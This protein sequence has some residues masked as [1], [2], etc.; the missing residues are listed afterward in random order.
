MVAKFWKS[1]GFLVQCEDAKKCVNSALECLMHDV[2]VDTKK[3]VDKLLKRTDV[4]VNMDKSMQD[5]R[6]SLK[7][8]KD[9]VGQVL[10]HVQELGKREPLFT[11]LIFQVDPALMGHAQQ[12]EKMLSLAGKFVEKY[13]INAEILS[14][15]GVRVSNVSSGEIQGGLCRNPSSCMIWSSKGCGWVS[16]SCPIKNVLDVLK[17]QLTTLGL[18]VV[19]VCHTYGASKTAQQLLDA[20][21]PVVI[22]INRALMQLGGAVATKLLFNV[23]HPV[24]DEMVRANAGNVA[25]VQN[26]LRT[27]LGKHLPGVSQLESAVLGVPVHVKTPRQSGTVLNE[28]KLETRSNLTTSDEKARKKQKKLA[29]ELQLV[30]CDVPYPSKLESKMGQALGDGNGRGGL[31]HIKGKGDTPFFRGRAVAFEAIMSCLV[32]DTFAVVWRIDTLADTVSLEAALE[33][34]GAEGCSILIWVDVAEKA[35][36][37]LIGEWLGGRM[38]ED[39]DYQFVLLL[40]SGES[41]ELQDASLRLSKQL[42]FEEF[43]IS[44]VKDASTSLVKAH[45]LHEDLRFSFSEG[46]QR[47]SPFELVDEITFA[48]LVTKELPRIMGTQQDV[49]IAGF[50]EDGKDLIITVCVRDV[51][52]IKNL[53]HEV[54]TGFLD[55]KLGKSLSQKLSP[56]DGVNGGVA[57]SGGDM[58]LPVGIA[59]PRNITVECDL[60][61]FAKSFEHAILAMDKLTAHQTEKMEELRGLDCVHLYA[62]AGAGKTFV[63]LHLM[64]LALFGP[65]GDQEP[66]IM[67]LFV[68]MNEALALFVVKW[69]CTRCEGAVRKRRMLEMIYLLYQPCDA[70]PRAVKLEA[71]RLS[72]EAVPAEQYDVVVVDEAHHVYSDELV[73]GMVEEYTA[74]LL[75]SSRPDP[76]RDFPRFLILSDVSQS[77][78]LKPQY[79]PDL[80]PVHL[81]EVVRSSQRILA[82][83]A[84]FQLHEGKD[85]LDATTCQNSVA[86]PPLKSVIFEL[87]AGDDIM[88]R[89]VDQTVQALLIH[90]AATF[91]RLSFHD[92]VAII[93]PDD[94]FRDEFLAKIAEPKGLAARLQEQVA[95]LKKRR[96]AGG[97]AGKE[98]QGLEELLRKIQG[99]SERRFKV[100]GAAEASRYVLERNTP[101]DEEQMILVDTVENFHGLE[102]LIVIAVG[103]DEVGGPEATTRSRARLYCAVTRAQLFV[104]VVNKFPRGGLLEFLGH[105]ELQK[106]H[107]EVDTKVVDRSAA[108][109]LMKKAEAEKLEKLEELKRWLVSVELATTAGALEKVGVEGT[110]ELKRLSEA[111]FEKLM[112]AMEEA[113]FDLLLEKVRGLGHASA[114]SSAV[115]LRVAVAARKAQRQLQED[116]RQK[117][118]ARVAD[119]LST[120]LASVGLTVAAASLK[121]VG[122][123][124]K[125]ELKSL[126]EAKFEKLMVAM[127]EA[128]FDL[129]LEKVKG[130]GHE[131]APSSAEKL[132]EKKRDTVAARE[133]ERQRQADLSLL[134]QQRRQKEEA[135]VA[136]ELSKW[137][138]S[139]GLTSTAVAAALKE[140]G[141][142]GKDDLKRLSDAKFE[143][144]MV[145]MSEADF[146]LLLEN[147]RGLGHESAPSSAEELREAVAA[148]KQR[149]RRRVWRS[150]RSRTPFGTQVVTGRWRRLGSQSSCRSERIRLDT[151]G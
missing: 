136:D 46:A 80:Q 56:P 25:L 83:A 72:T 78:T 131:S 91:P 67:I 79:P 92:R 115:E 111:K 1:G 119:E 73:R 135:R 107:R 26:T 52:F 128:D 58:G 22:S 88:E 148:R 150:R 9:E 104:V 112:A 15:G 47:R 97:I 68:V 53:S 65:N 71:G 149:R 45:S 60:S 114:P 101:L 49:P 89:Y 32:N 20:G 98:T 74:P 57:S 126:S 31:W 133:A 5:V 6:L 129:L 21:V 134:E 50:F 127:E 137:L 34:H 109:D 30:V 116:Q 19:V 14:N 7:A 12:R 120:W 8:I 35:E 123:K 66:D 23:I 95:E 141:A 147:V 139:V 110:D 69:L 142:K 151:R 113:D 61:G 37:E 4:L 86:G 132:R 18:Q 138:A 85:Q 122:V 39:D 130:L 108:T 16:D 105:V 125:D 28:L 62:P 90:V 117:E 144:L 81:T 43:W 100:V 24:I 3:G 102:R 48:E 36:W 106:E 99:V 145:A 40:T 76:P 118:E 41:N 2:N 75:A 29:T 42:S 143:K 87:A 17:Q 146:D 70:G 77:F 59:G 63:A 51:V 84:A 13:Q 94:G 54:L 103:L 38:L 121:K 64:L 93:V 140:V 124:G 10:G 55:K 82:G 11:E 33:K 44:D 96:D 27:L